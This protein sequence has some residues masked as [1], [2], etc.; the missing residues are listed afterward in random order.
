[1]Y[2]LQHPS[3]ATPS[4]SR[5]PRDNYSRKSR[6]LSLLCEHFIA[7]FCKEVDFLINIESASTALQVERRRIYDILNVLDAF[8]MIQ[9]H[10]KGQYVSHL[11]FMLY[12]LLNIFPDPND[13]PSPV[14]DVCRYIFK[15]ANAFRKK[16]DSLLVE[17][18][19]ELQSIQG[20]EDNKQER[21]MTRLTQR[22]AQMFL[23]SPNKTLE[24]SNA[25]AALLGVSENDGK[26]KTKIRRLYDIANI[27]RYRQY[28]NQNMVLR[29]HERRLLTDNN[30]FI[31]YSFV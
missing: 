8:S 22:F 7:R 11:S 25:A 23:L 31:Q 4:T 3:P 2:N 1:M 10:L 15:G 20:Q 26:T 21:S 5:K 13:P 18:Q 16:L 12:I 27:M 14:H 17:A 19:H 6:S 30:P 28:H 9:K 29:S 24:L